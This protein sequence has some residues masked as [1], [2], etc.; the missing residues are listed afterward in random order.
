[1]PDESSI[2]TEERWNIDR[3]LSDLRGIIKTVIDNNIE[4]KINQ[5]KN[6]NNNTINTNKHPNSIKIL[7]PIIQQLIEF[8]NHDFEYNLSKLEEFLYS[9]KSINNTNDATHDS[10]TNI[11]NNEKENSNRLPRF[12]CGVLFI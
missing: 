8:E 11:N 6:D 1:M 7:N 3:V 5:R 12:G 4:N 2:L 10:N 9:F